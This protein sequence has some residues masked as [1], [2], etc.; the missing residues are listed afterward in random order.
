MSLYWNAEVSI[1]TKWKTSIRA[2][3]SGIVV[4]FLLSVVASAADLSGRYAVTGSNPDGSTYRGDATFRADAKSC[5][6]NWVTGKSKSA[7]NCRLVGKTLTVR[8]TLQ[9]SRGVVVYTMRDNG[10]RFVGKWWMLHSPK[11]QGRE[12]LY[13]RK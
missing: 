4:L 11:S 6:V 5:R 12:T 2:L 9:G 10:R 8:F 13:R 7:G 3:A 1:V